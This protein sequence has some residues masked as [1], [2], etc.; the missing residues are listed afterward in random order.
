MTNTQKRAILQMKANGDGA[1]KIAS[2]L[3]IPLSTVK[4]FLRR[5]KQTMFADSEAQR[6]KEIK[7]KVT[8]APCKHCGDT[9]AQLPGMKKRAF[10]SDKCKTSWWNRHRAEAGRKSVTAYVCARCG[11]T[12]L[13]NAPSRKYCGLPCYHNARAK[14]ENH[15][16]TEPV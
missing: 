1:R 11:K 7:V 4:S 15:H 2:T 6:V 10:C 3:D 16:D 14:K 13:S 12:F 9:V 8:Y 5:W